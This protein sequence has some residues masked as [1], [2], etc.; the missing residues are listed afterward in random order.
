VDRGACR[1]AT[2]DAKSTASG[3][4]SMQNGYVKNVRPAESE[5]AALA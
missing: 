2:V 4:A 5:A 1:H 3:F